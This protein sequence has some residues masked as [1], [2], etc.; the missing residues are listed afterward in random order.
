MVKIH[1]VIKIKG[2]HSVT[3]F[4]VVHCLP[5]INICDVYIYINYINGEISLC[6]NVFNI[7]VKCDEKF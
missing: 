4:A 7:H 6:A 3:F 2:T 5:T 1:Y